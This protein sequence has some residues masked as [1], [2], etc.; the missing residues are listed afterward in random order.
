LIRYNAKNHPI[1]FQI[2]GEAI[3]KSVSGPK[4]DAE[5]TIIEEDKPIGDD[6]SE[7]ENSD[8]KEDPE[9]D[10]K[11]IKYIKESTKT[12]KGKKRKNTAS[13]SSATKKKL[14]SKK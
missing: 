3:K 2:G 10:I 12:T 13:T 7:D 8:E 4:E 6:L 5:G 14:K 11:D 9:N 1:L